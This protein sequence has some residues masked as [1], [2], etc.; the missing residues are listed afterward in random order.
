MYLL[1]MNATLIYVNL[2]IIYWKASTTNCA[3]CAQQID[4]ETTDEITDPS[5]A[6]LQVV[7]F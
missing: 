6:F 5:L 1:S 3:L 7:F 4:L 2:L